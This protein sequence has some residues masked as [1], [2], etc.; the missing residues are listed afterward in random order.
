MDVKD[1]YVVNNNRGSYTHRTR[2]SSISSLYDKVEVLANR[3][4][5]A[6]FALRGIPGV[7]KI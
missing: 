5:M 2:N 7:N 6:D 3:K 1:A 4:S